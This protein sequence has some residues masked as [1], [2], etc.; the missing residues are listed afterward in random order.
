MMKDTT[1]IYITTHVVGSFEDDKNPVLKTNIVKQNFL[2]PLF[3]NNSIKF[4]IFED[5][6]SFLV[7]KIYDNKGY[8]I[9]KSIIPIF[10]MMEGYRN[11]LL[12]DSQCHEIE[13]AM[14][15]IYSK[16]I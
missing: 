15:I 5:S 2:H 3:E 7:I 12:Y 1:E 10:C 6:L 11:V 14:L 16:R 8:V 9:A 4:S 13:N